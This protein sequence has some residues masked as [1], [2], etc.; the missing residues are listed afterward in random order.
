MRNVYSPQP[1]FK[2]PPLRQERHS[3][4]HRIEHIPLLIRHLETLQKLHILLLERL[5]RPADNL[6]SPE[7]ET[8]AYALQLFQTSHGSEP[9]LLM[10]ASTMVIVPVIVLFFFTQRYFI[11]GITLTGI[12]G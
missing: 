6:S 1:S 9:A 8:L 3:S 7:K 4:I 5:P 11:Q 2:I 12:K 10:A